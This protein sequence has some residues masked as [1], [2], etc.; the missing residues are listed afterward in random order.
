M[1]LKY[2]HLIIF[3]FQFCAYGV[4]R[5]KLPNPEL[6]YAKVEWWFPS[7]LPPKLHITLSYFEIG[8]IW[9]DFAK[10][11]VQEKRKIK[12]EY[13]KIK[14]ELI[15]AKNTLLSNPKFNELFKRELANNETFALRGIDIISTH[16]DFYNHFVLNTSSSFPFGTKRNIEKFKR[17]FEKGDPFGTEVVKTRQGKKVFPKY[18][19]YI[20]AKFE[21]NMVDFRNKLCTNPI[22]NKFPQN[23]L[24]G[25]LPHMTLAKIDG[26]KDVSKLISAISKANTQLSKETKQSKSFKLK[27]IEREHPNQHKIYLL[28]DKAH[29][30]NMIFMLVIGWKTLVGKLIKNIVKEFNEYRKI[31]KNRETNTEHSFEHDIFEEFKQFNLIS[32]L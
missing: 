24:S 3:V 30:S 11:S 25:Y 7:Y 10:K 1:K 19:W 12:K 22:F 26:I 8:D 6:D 32:R 16:P 9:K 29:K 5:D 27:D 4:N 17:I 20:V 2:I 14:E 18:H 31:S 23:D 21:D 13:P 15:Q 28:L